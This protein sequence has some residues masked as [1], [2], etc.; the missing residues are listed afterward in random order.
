MSEH[1]FVISAYGESQFLEDCIQ[2]LLHQTVQ[3]EIFVYINES[4]P[5]V[6]GIC[7]KYGL[8]LKTGQGGGI[9]RDWN[10]SLSLVKTP[11][12]TIAHQDD[13]YESEYA[14]S[15]LEQ[16]SKQKDATIVFSDYAEYRDQQVVPPNRNLK[17]KTFM[18]QLMSLFP[19]SKFWKK[20]VL[21]LGNPICC[22][23]VSYNRNKLRDF[24]FRE[25]LKTSL[26]WYAWYD[27]NEHYPGAF[28]YVPKKLM[29]HRIHSES[30][31]TAT[32]SDNTRSKEDMYMYQLMWPRFIASFLMKF[33]EK[34]Q[35]TNSQ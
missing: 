23:A 13:L 34:S 29:Y 8:S 9:G 15:I 5:Y 24:S 19:S 28:I 6:E 14:Q 31:T 7:K 3:S 22:P 17:I 20:R 32:I 10:Q 26:D 18:L 4:N 16:F 27:I 30:E 21:S 35:Q 12:V 1:T 33:Y 11:Y 2:S 25:D